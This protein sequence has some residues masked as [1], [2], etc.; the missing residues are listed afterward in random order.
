MEI[1]N[2]LLEIRG[3]VILVT[4]WQKAWP[5]LRLD[6]LWKVEFM[7]CKTGYLTEEIFKQ[8]IEGVA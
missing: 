5:C 3:K 1:K 2:T 4:K 6:V 8:S 7:N